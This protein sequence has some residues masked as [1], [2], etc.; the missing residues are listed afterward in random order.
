MVLL[1]LLI[2]LAL[3]RCVC[4]CVAHEKAH[5]RCF[6]FAVYSLNEHINSGRLHCTTDAFPRCHHGVFL[7]GGER[8]PWIRCRWWRRFTGAGR[9]YRIGFCACC[10]F[11]QFTTHFCRCVLC[12]Y[13][14]SSSLI[15]SFSYLLA[16]L[17]RTLFFSLL[18]LLLLSFL[19]LF[20]KFFFRRF[21]LT[22]EFNE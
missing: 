20:L 12:W 22:D 18:L 17:V 9:I 21:S 16:L 11:T 3:S 1:L 15:R 8:Q 7:A 13:L 10:Q 4:M 5:R 6:L 19:F 2:S 14:V